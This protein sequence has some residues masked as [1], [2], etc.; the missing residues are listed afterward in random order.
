MASSKDSVAQ[1]VGEE[2]DRINDG[3][4]AKLGI[5]AIPNSSIKKTFVDR[6]KAELQ[7]LT[8]GNALTTMSQSYVKRDWLWQAKTFASCNKIIAIKMLSGKMLSGTIHTNINRNRGDDDQRK[9]LC[10]HCHEKAETDLHVLNE[11]T[12]T[13]HARSKRHNLVVSKIGKELK[14]ID[15]TVWLKRRL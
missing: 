2:Q 10:R 8:N 5:H 12:K 7:K 3:H 9:N 15:Y 11:C 4:L 1:T 14:K 6:R 13:H